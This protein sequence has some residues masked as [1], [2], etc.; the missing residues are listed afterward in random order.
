MTIAFI[1]HNSLQLVKCQQ[2]DCP[3]TN[4]TAIEQWQLWSKLTDITQKKVL[5][6]YILAQIPLIKQHTII[7]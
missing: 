7:N 3:W 2:T 4:K 6:D 1:E 5:S